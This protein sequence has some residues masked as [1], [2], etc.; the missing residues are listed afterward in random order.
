MEKMFY[1]LIKREAKDK[2][3]LWKQ[4]LVFQNVCVCV[5]VLQMLMKCESGVWFVPAPE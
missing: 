1:N 4:D 3:L 2:N 5:C